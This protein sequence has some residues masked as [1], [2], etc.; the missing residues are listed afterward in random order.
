MM[1]SSPKPK[2]TTGSAAAAAL[3]PAAAPGSAA[4][5]PE[6]R[7]G[8]LTLIAHLHA[9]AKNDNLE[10]FQ[11]VLEYCN[12]NASRHSKLGHHHDTLRV[13]FNTPYEGRTLLALLVSCGLIPQIEMLLFNKPEPKRY[14]QRPDGTWALAEAKISSSL[15][16]TP[17]AEGGVALTQAKVSSP[18]ADLYATNTTEGNF[19]HTAIIARR[20]ITLLATIFKWLPA[21]SITK[22]CENANGAGDTPLLCAVRNGSLPDYK[23]AA[24]FLVKAGGR[25]ALEMRDKKG[26]TPFLLAVREGNWDLAKTLHA[27]DANALAVNTIDGDTALHLAVKVKNKEDGQLEMVRW[28]VEVAKLNPTT[29]NNAEEIA[30]SVSHAGATQDHLKPTASAW[31]RQQKHEQMACAA[32]D[33]RDLVALRHATTADE[34]TPDI[35]PLPADSKVLTRIL[36]SAARIRGEDLP[37]Y[38]DCCLRAGATVNA[39]LL[40]ELINGSLPQAHVDRRLDR[41]WLGDLCTA[42]LRVFEGLLACPKFDA[43]LKNQFLLQVLQKET[44]RQAVWSLQQKAL[45]VDLLTKSGAAPNIL[46][47][48]WLD[49]ISFSCLPK[50]EHRDDGYITRRDLPAAQAFVANLFRHISPEG[51]RQALLNAIGTYTKDHLDYYVKPLIAIQNSG[52][53]DMAVLHYMAKYDP[54]AEVLTTYLRDPLALF[55]QPAGD[56]PVNY[57]LWG[58]DLSRPSNWLIKCNYPLD[59][60]FVEANKEIFEK[61]LAERK[62]A[63]DGN[64]V[65]MAV[66]LETLIRE[67]KPATEDSPYPALNPKLLAARDAKE[68]EAG[69]PIVTDTE[70]KAATGP[71]APPAPITTKGAVIPAGPVAADAKLSAATSPAAPPAAI[72]AK[73]AVIPAGNKLFTYL[74]RYGYGEATKPGMQPSNYQIC[75]GFVFN[76]ILTGADDETVLCA[77]K[78]ALK[79]TTIKSKWKKE[80][81]PHCQMLNALLQEAAAKGKELAT[82]PVRPEHRLELYDEKDAQC[83]GLKFYA[84]EF[85][86]YMQTHGLQQL[87]EPVLTV[88]AKMAAGTRATTFGGM[89]TPSPSFSSDMEKGAVPLA[90][91]RDQR[92]GRMR[93]LG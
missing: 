89:M 58:K 41:T 14:M 30:Y 88:P 33:S 47:K 85:R 80:T 23:A 39:A 38:I 53:T 15:S 40:E 42:H 69:A 59:K 2:S 1:P 71:A 31:L 86:A 83:L 19:V 37:S 56:V 35:Q 27:E 36:A 5:A 61:V 45:F 68:D 21:E 17:T 3:G 46:D 78:A 7:P 48:R 24:C 81:D 62:A 75:C 91:V 4:A 60:K 50:I 77:V 63:H 28:L 6:I 73:R 84:Q 12:T 76:K 51:R 82:K 9:E 93:Q 44:N 92:V 87:R 29:P 90:S 70:L 65:M 10:S 32:I 16:L 52:V 54:E 22:L 67:A 20:D 74:R 66:E 13:L 11:E 26:D 25:V 8:Y 57:N 18:L 64:C 43:T 79:K 55:L 72:T 34:K 49:A